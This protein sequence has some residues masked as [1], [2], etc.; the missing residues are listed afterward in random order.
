MKKSLKTSEPG[1][2]SSAD[3]SRIND[4]CCD[5]LTCIFQ[6]QEVWPQMTEGIKYMLSH[7][8]I[9]AFSF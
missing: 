5:I 6:T 3:L 2:D 8:E 7:F 9:Q 4:P 1:Q